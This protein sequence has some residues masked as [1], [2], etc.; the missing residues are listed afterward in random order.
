M[1]L[2]PCKL[3]N[4]MN[5]DYSGESHETRHESFCSCLQVSPC[6]GRILHFGKVDCGRIEQVKGVS[7][8]LPAFLGPK[9]WEQKVPSEDAARMLFGDDQKGRIFSFPGEPRRDTLIANP[10]AVKSWSRAW[11]KSVLLRYLSR[12]RGLSS[13]SL[14]RWVERALS[15]AYR[16]WD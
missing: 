14:S 7:Y 8:S 13:L 3:L 15:Q 10:T 5:S 16:R 12:A 2:V 1:N 6:D 4:I 11:D 9:T